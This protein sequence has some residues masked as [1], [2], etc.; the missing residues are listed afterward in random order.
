MVFLKYFFG[1][2]ER[3]GKLP[4]SFGSASSTGF[5]NPSVEVLVWTMGVP[6]ARSLGFLGVKLSGLPQSHLTAMGQRIFGLQV[7]NPSPNDVV[8]GGTPEVEE[9]HLDLQ[10][11]H[12]H[13]TP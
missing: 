3:L 12:K 7:A 10:T 2:L 9:E 1:L 13:R 4:R 8:F 6:R 5:G 11:T